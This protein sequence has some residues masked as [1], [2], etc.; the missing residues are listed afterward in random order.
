MPGVLR[1][2]FSGGG[3]ILETERLWASSWC[4]RLVWDRARLG[5]SG[6]SV[7]DE[8]VEERGWLV[9]VAV[10]LGKYDVDGF[11]SM[12]ELP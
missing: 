5:T 8:D 4:E 7:V 1:A 3:D 6:A 11:A 12:G 2:A 10:R 9:T